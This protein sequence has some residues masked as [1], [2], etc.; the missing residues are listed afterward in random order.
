MKKQKKAVKNNLYTGELSFSA[1]QRF[2]VLE[3][4]RA[5]GSIAEV[6]RS[7]HI[8]RQT[9]RLWERRY[10]AGG[11]GGL[12]D[13]PRPPSPGRPKRITAGLKRVLLDIVK[14][15][16]SDGCVALGRQL[17]ALG[18]KVSSPTI[19]KCLISLELGK[20][21]QRLAWVDSGCLLLGEP[22]CTPIE[23]SASQSAL[24]QAK[25]Y[26]FT[27]IPGRANRSLEVLYPTFEQVSKASGLSLREILAAA[28]LGNWADARVRF[29]TRIADH[30]LKERHRRDSQRLSAGAL[31]VAAMAVDET[32][33][34]LKEHQQ[35][36]PKELLQ[37]VKAL[38]ASY[39][40]IKG[41][42][43]GT[44]PRSHSHDEH[45]Q[46]SPSLNKEI[47]TSLGNKQVQG[48]QVAR[49]RSL[50]FTGIAPDGPDPGIPSPT[51]RQVASH[52]NLPTRWLQRYAH[53]HR[54]VKDRREADL[55][56]IQHRLDRLQGQLGPFWIENMIN[57]IMHVCF[58]YPSLANIALVTENQ[59]LRDLLRL[60]NV[61]FE[62]IT[63]TNLIEFDQKVARGEVLHSTKNHAILGHFS[64]N[65]SR[66]FAIKGPGFLNTGFHSAGRAPQ[67]EPPLGP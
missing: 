31:S 56:T 43:G 29:V 30:D 9:F 42:F 11:L 49:A 41:V 51:I 34:W 61:L 13:R 22:C 12:H 21:S 23:R 66:A 62:T 3:D 37:S 39:L 16:P 20:Q 17:E 60:T 48:T 26:Y 52:L 59:S 55:K 54:W 33:R 2:Q 65:P 38:K 44:L 15:H 10:A 32:V 4:A 45:R 53:S 63:L 6:C 24:E 58:V 67:G 27:G 19:Q 40:L 8:T 47:I 1:E 64:N 36:K 57:R 46:P 28:E 5:L 35:P 50:F 25:A 18:I 14:N 7:A